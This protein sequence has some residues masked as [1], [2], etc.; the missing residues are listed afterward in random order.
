MHIII[1]RAHNKL[2]SRAPEHKNT[3]TGRKQGTHGAA[4]VDDQLDQCFCLL[5]ELLSFG[6]I[7]T[8]AL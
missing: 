3:G 6:Q 1:N 2:L 8:A 5:L 4:R 7:S